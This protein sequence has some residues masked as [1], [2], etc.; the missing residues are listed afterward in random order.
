M[1]I[2]KNCCNNSAYAENYHGIWIVRCSKCNRQTGKHK[3]IDMAKKEWD[4][5]C[6]N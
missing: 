6:T 4:N 1:K 2:K 3:T 5:S